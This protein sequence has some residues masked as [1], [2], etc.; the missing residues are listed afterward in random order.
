[1]V[2]CLRSD[3]KE[4]RRRK[5]E[6][7]NTYN[8]VQKKNDLALLFDPFYASALIAM[9]QDARSLTLDKEIQV[10]PSSCYSFIYRRAL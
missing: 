9:A 2:G 6:W 5:Q 7:R 3:I 4:S 10:K 8:T 1:M